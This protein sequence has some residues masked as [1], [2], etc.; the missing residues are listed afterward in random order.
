MNAEDR[1]EG[2]PPDPDCVTLRT[3]GALKRIM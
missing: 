2:I 3:H 1:I